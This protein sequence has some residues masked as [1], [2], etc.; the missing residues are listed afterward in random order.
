MMAM[1]AMVA[2]RW[3]KLHGEDDAENG[4]DDG[5]ENDD[6]DGRGLIMQRK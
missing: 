4:Y 2:R 5:D 6:G 1:V 3:S